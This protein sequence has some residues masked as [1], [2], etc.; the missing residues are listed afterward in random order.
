M[1]SRRSR[2]YWP[3]MRWK[4]SWP[5]ARCSGVMSIAMVRGPLTAHGLFEGA[6]VGGVAAGGAD[7]PG[8]QQVQQPVEAGP[9]A[10]VRRRQGQQGQHLD[11]VLVDEQVMPL[12]PR[13]LGQ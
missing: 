2:P 6:V 4:L 7:P 1:K 11:Q 9:A 10:A 8:V 3:T 5:I 12:G 13:V